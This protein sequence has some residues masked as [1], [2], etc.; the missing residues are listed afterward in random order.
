MPLLSAAEDHKCHSCPPRTGNGGHSFHPN[1]QKRLQKIAW[2]AESRLGPCGWK[3]GIK[4]PLCL[5]STVQATDCGLNVGGDF[6]AHFSP[7]QWQ[8]TSQCTLAVHHF[9]T[10]VSHLLLATLV[11]I[12]HLTAK[13]QLTQT[14]FLNV[15]CVQGRMNL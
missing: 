2:S 15:Q 4:D 9:M 10:T 12:M 8:Y 3:R 13:L 11:R 7:A 14:S 5:V 6:L 1:R